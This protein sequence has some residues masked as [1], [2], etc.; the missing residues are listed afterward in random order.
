MRR[1]LIDRPYD[2][3][4]SAM[5]LW[6]EISSDEIHRQGFRAY[7]QGFRAFNKCN[8]MT[9]IRARGAST[10]RGATASGEQ[11]HSHHGAVSLG[12]QD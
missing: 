10:T 9:I 5:R 8:V 12:S 2:A 11:G 1:V 6:G 4:R 3:Y 7:K